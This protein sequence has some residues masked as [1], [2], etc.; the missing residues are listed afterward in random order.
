MQRVPEWTIE[1]Q[2]R[3]YPVLPNG[4][5]AGRGQEN[6]IVLNDDQV[7]RHHATLWVAQGGVFI[8]DEGSTNGTYVNG[9]G[10]VGAVPLRPGDQI[11]IGRTT[12]RAQLGGGVS[13][14]PPMPAAYRTTNQTGIIVVGIIFLI[15]VVVAGIAFMFVSKSPSS[16]NIALVAQSPTQTLATLTGTPVAALTTPI[17]LPTS[18]PTLP[19]PTNTPAIPTAT[20]VQVNVRQRALMASVW[21]V[22]PTEKKD[23]Y[24]TGSGSIIDKRGLIL[25][26]FHV[27]R[28]P[29]TGQTYNSKDA[30]VV[31]VNSSPDRTPDRLFVAQVVGQDANLDLAILKLIGMANGKLLPTNLDLSVVTLSEGIVSGFLSDRAWMKTD[32]EVNPGNSGGM[33]INA[34]GELIGIPTRKRNDPQLGGQLGILRPINLAKPLIEKAK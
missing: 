31:A 1:T 26:N 2:G 15:T 20:P 27:V 30:I 23:E 11:Q 25:T 14:H 3:Q 22:V 9:R 17:A 7:S 32:A 6:S 16:S 28:D 8:R 18:S 21:I 33:A 24:V 4:L 10:I 5:R 34:A 13:A 29:E 12:L 19:A